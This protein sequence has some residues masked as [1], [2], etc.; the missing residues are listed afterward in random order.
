MPTTDMDHERRVI[1]ANHAH[2]MTYVNECKYLRI[3]IRLLRGQ[4]VGF[5]DKKLMSELE[6]K[7][8]YFKEW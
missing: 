4:F 3:K 6:E 5:A 1:D 8:P 2:L 7:Y